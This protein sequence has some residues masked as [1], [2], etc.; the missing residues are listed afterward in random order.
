MEWGPDWYVLRNGLA[1]HLSEARA[2][3]CGETQKLITRDAVIC[4]N[5][6]CIRR[7]GERVWAILDTTTGVVTEARRK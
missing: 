6:K 2:C 3:S 4:P 1:I 5:P 7:R